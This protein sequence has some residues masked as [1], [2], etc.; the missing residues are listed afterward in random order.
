MSKAAMDI[1]RE[2]EALLASRPDTFEGNK[3]FTLSEKYLLSQYSGA[4]GKAAAGARG[5]GLL[6]EYYTPM[7]LCEKM[8]ELAL[9]F[10]E[11]PRY[12]LEPAAGTGN[13]L[14][15]MP[16]SVEAAMAFELNRTAARIARIRA[17]KATVLTLPFEAAFLEP[18]RFTNR[19]R[20]TWLGHAPYDLVIGNPPYGV[21]TGVKAALFRKPDLKTFEV[22]F[23]YW[24]L[25]V[26][27]DGGL[28]V[29]VI[30]SSFLRSDE[31]YAKQK[32]LL[33]KRCDLVDAYRLPK[34]F[35]STTISTDIVVLRK[36]SKR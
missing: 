1:S 16:D 30:P 14:A 32:A 23:L 34:V 35:D 17:P 2:V 20:V 5:Q 29:M 26:L 12:V 7:W 9:H 33:E 19:S 25:E 6:Y 27:R 3:G 13:L 11:S 4:G 8:W 10:G 31:R 15:L 22:F 36:K 28:L 18:P 24:G 21:H